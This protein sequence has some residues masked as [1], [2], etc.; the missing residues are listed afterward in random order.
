MNKPT[1][2]HENQKNTYTHKPFKHL[3]TPCNRKRANDS[4]SRKVGYAHV[5]PNQAYDAHN[6]QDENDQKDNGQDCL[7]ADHVKTPY[8]LNVSR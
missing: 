6:G 3:L 8:F 5:W 1:K 4:Q 2:E 7:D